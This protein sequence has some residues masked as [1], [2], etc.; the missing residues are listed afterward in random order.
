LTLDIFYLIYS[1]EKQTYD[2]PSTVF[3]ALE[4]FTDSLN[5]TSGLVKYAK[6]FEI[7]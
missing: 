3:M 7:L 5:T 4:L 1:K 6:E 2:V